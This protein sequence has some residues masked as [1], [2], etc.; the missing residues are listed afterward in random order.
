MD[1]EQCLKTQIETLPIGKIKNK[2][3]LEKFISEKMGEELPLDR[4]Q[5]YTWLAPNYEGDKM[6]LIWKS[7]HSFADGVSCMAFHLQIDK[8]YDISKLIQ[9]PRVRFY[10]R[11]FFRLM[12]PFELIKIGFQELTRKVDVNPLHPA[13]FTLTGKKKAVF[14]EP[15]PF[16]EIKDV[17]KKLGVTINDLMTASLSVAVKK[18]FEAKGD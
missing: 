6:V 1:A 10:W 14:S 9:F 13:N 12:I 16:Q 15:I 8:E 2:P 17:S 5:W 18:Y 3:D 7:H 11:L 4:P